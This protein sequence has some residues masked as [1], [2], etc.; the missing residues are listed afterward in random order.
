MNEQLLIPDKL[1]VGFVARDDT[2]TKKLGYVIYYD[3]KGV[4]RKE[5]SWQ[6]WRNHKIPPVEVS[7]EPTEGFV[8]NKGVGGQR[9]SYGWNARNEAIRVYDP[10][11]F[12]FE[13]SVLN[14][15]F[16]LKECN[17]HKGA[18]LEGKF[19]YAWNGGGLVLLPE[20]SLDYQ[21]SKKF[22]ELQGKDVK[23]KE[24]VEGTSYTTKR[25][26]TLIYIGRLDY[27]FV[28]S[29]GPYESKK[30]QKG[31]LKKYV[32]WDGK[33]FIFQDSVNNI[34]KQTSETVVLNFAELRDKY[35]KSPNGSKVVELFTKTF[36][37]KDPK[38]DM[39]YYE[40]QGVN[41]QEYI[42]FALRDET[43]YKGSGWHN[44]PSKK[45][46]C[47]HTS[48]RIYMK[49]GIVRSSSLSSISIPPNSDADGYRYTD[50]HGQKHTWFKP[51]FKRLYAKLESGAKFRINYGHFVAKNTSKDDVLEEEF[52]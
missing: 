8:L 10:R 31:V 13:I 16:I 20:C 11:D 51:T 7:N 5:T 18:A 44:E 33:Q 2:Y 43:F 30:N 24:L 26:Q 36:E 6:S 40:Q 50:R 38:K 42:E 47:I 52:V 23:G 37:P 28:V 17:C 45:V 15:L 49:N 39:W 32:F 35:Y 12:E 41:G 21:S 14:L 29:D 9:H 48:Y 25:Q 46:E 27:H 3:Q 4:L 1:K 34:A 19:V 22:T